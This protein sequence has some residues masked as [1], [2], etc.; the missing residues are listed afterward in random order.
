MGTHPIFESDFDCLTDVKQCSVCARVLAP[1][2]GFVSTR[3]V[4]CAFRR[5]WA[6]KCLCATSPTSTLATSTTAKRRSPP[7]SPSVSTNTCRNS[8]LS[9]ITRRERHD[10][11]CL[12]RANGDR[13][14]RSIHG[15]IGQD[16]GGHGRS[17]QDL[18]R[19]DREASE[20]MVRHETRIEKGTL[21]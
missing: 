10:E 8:T 4:R 9:K 2:S 5:R 15:A 12:P 14:G 3:T 13:G 7:P 20:R 17:H 11:L 18:R 6:R 16:D 21:G 1:S 19:P